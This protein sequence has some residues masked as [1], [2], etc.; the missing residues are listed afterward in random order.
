MDHTDGQGSTRW[1]EKAE[2]DAKG[3]DIIGW[4]LAS[5]TTVLNRKGLG[6]F[7]L[8]GK[9][10][11][12]WDPGHFIGLERQECASRDSQFLH[13]C[14]NTCG[15]LNSQ[16]TTCHINPI[17]SSHLSYLTLLSSKTDIAFRDGETEVLTSSESRKT[18][19]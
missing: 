6:D 4:L 13:A 18:G 8:K 15:A 1:W 11:N 7:V 5:S 12:F 9:S 14:T 16:I 2:G 17:P 10:L 19:V 3:G